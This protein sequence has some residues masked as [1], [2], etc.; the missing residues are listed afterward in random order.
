MGCFSKVQS[1]TYNGGVCS[2]YFVRSNN[3][4]QT[5]L[6]AYYLS[7]GSKHFERLEVHENLE[8]YNLNVMDTLNGRNLTD[9]ILN[10]VTLTTNQVKFLKKIVEFHTASCPHHGPPQLS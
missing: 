10:R 4:N 1:K 6:S 5:V 2:K 8:A 9:F 7:P 3:V